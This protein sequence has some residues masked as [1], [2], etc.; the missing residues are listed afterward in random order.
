[1]MAAMTERVHQRISALVKVGRYGEA[2]AM[3]R[4]DRRLSKDDAADLEEWVLTCQDLQRAS[5][6]PMR[7]RRLPRRSRAKLAHMYRRKLREL[8]ELH[9][10]DAA[11]DW[12]IEEVVSVSVYGGDVRMAYS[13]GIVRPDGGA[14]LCDEAY[15]IW[16]AGLDEEELMRD[17][18][19]RR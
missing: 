16:F 11:S 1:M 8:R 17:S 14:G 4:D 9:E 7:S 12:W 13:D 5:G 19:I 10:H 2:L 3:V 18:H 6:A 15:A